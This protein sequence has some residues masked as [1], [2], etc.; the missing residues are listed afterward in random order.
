M[1]TAPNPPSGKFYTLATPDTVKLC[2]GVIKKYHPE[3]DTTGAK[4]DLLM[5]FRAPDSE[6]PAMEEQRIRV[7]S[8]SS[9]VKLKDRVKGMGDCEII[10]DGDA[11]GEK[12]PQEKIAILDHALASF[13]V[14]RDKNGDFIWDDLNRPVI[15][16]KPYSH[17]IRWHAEV[18]SRQR[19]YSLEA[20]AL[21]HLF[22][23]QYCFSFV[24]E[25]MQPQ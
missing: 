2:E 3:L 15:K 16:I 7:F 12:S 5:V 19:N 24:S 22:A 1:T 23:E 11:W 6:S 14:K 9:V 17:V 25:L 20:G 21:R 4:V 10:L 8:K 18:A 13:E